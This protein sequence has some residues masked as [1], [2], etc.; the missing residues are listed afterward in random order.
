MRKILKMIRQIGLCL[1]LLLSGF[2]SYAINALPAYT[3]FYLPA[4]DGTTPKPYIEFYWQ[5]EPKTV[6][7]NKNADGYWVSKIKTEIQISTDTGVIVQ[8]KYYLQTTPATSIEA[9][10]LQN[11]IDLHRHTLPGGK[12]YISL[13]LSQDENRDVYTY[14]DSITLQEQNDIFYSELQLIDTSYETDLTDNIFLKNGNLQIP[15]CA[16]FLDNY[17]KLMH[18]YIELYGTEKVDTSALPL[19]QTTSISKKENS[20]VIYDLKQIDTITP[21]EVVPILG[22][23]RIDVLP[24][25]NYYL[26][27]VLKDGNGK[28]LAG[29]SMFF[30][31]INLK[32]VKLTDSTTDD[33]T[34]FE[35]VNVFDLS[36]TFVTKY[37]PSQL[38]AILKMLLPISS[39]NEENSINTFLKKPE[40]TYMRYFIYNFWKA[41]NKQDPEKEWKAYSKQVKET[42]KLFGSS[43]QP[44]YETDRGF[45]YLKYGPP[46]QR[47]TVQNEQGALP[48]EVW[49]YNSPGK[50][51]N[52][53]AFLFYNPGF[54]INE[55][56]LLHSTVIGE[57]RNTNWRSLLYVNGSQSNNLNSRAEQIFQG[58]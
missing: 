10:E 49:Q 56:R 36:N 54:M 39:P 50:Q 28:K 13:K 12:I 3:I 52:Q 33:S 55:Y 20:F 30:Q 51:S 29:R 2:T 19:I 21:A 14:E 7:F 5:V 45:M 53:G 43:M 8:D 1:L 48:Y 42:L 18:Y 9:A 23:F 31:R 37:T 38:M 58:Q 57:V 27:T 46:D 17:R 24:S 26:N 47:Y 4:V 40:E 6:Q 44:G 22:D 15:L 25:G 34:V 35:N 32:P 41:R 16:D 11:I